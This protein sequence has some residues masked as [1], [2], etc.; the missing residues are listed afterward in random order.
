MVEETW[1]DYLP[2]CH[3][4]PVRVEKVRLLEYLRIVHHLFTKQLFNVCISKICQYF[5]NIRKKSNVNYN[6]RQVHI[7]WRY[8]ADFL[9][10]VGLSKNMQN[11]E[12]PN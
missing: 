4:L 2:T 8:M 11:G 7:F 3:D 5:L 9:N 6:F 10:K 12:A 1:T